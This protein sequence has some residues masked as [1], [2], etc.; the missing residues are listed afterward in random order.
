MVSGSKVLTVLYCTVLKQD[1]QQNHMIHWLCQ[2][3][4][5]ETSSEGVGE[6]ERES[7]GQ[8]EKKTRGR[9]NE[10]RCSG[11][12]NK[13]MVLRAHGLI[14]EKDFKDHKT[15]IMKASRRYHKDLQTGEN[16]DR[17]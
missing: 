13:R 15:S 11:T 16:G 6:V 5:R 7:E 3:P 10:E 9:W 8:R 17:P 4:N 12:R 1:G 2:E 14:E